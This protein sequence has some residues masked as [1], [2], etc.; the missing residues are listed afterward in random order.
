MWSSPKTCSATVSGHAWCNCSFLL[1]LLCPTVP[2]PSLKIGVSL[3]CGDWRISPHSGDWRSTRSD[4]PSQHPC[5]GCSRAGCSANVTCLYCILEKL[6]LVFLL[7]YCN[8]HWPPH[9]AQESRTCRYYITDLFLVVGSFCAL[10]K[11]DGINGALAGRE[12]LGKL[13]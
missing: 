5:T 2:F 3:N 12:C 10:L 4:P 8:Q 1:V 9:N 13:L 6:D 11:A 7:G